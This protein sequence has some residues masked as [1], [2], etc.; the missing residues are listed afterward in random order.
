MTETMWAPMRDPPSG[1][2]PNC[3]NQPCLDGYTGLSTCP[4]CSPYA[5]ARY[6]WDAEQRGRAN[7]L[8]EIAHLKRENERL[9]HKREQAQHAYDDIRASHRALT[10][11][12]DENSAKLQELQ[13]QLDEPTVELLPVTM[14]DRVHEVF[15]IMQ[16]WKDRYAKDGRSQQF[17]DGYQKALTELRGF[18]WPLEQ[19]RQ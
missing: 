19:E 17:L 8:D 2:S 12:R 11:A 18:M 1:R 9:E 7:A 13:R 6:S 3:I 10:I 4:S 14:R 16:N 15:V 5:Q